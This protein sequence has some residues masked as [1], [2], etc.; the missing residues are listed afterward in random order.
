M[1]STYF[2]ILI[3]ALLAAGT[4]FVILTLSSLLGRKVS[5][6]AKLET[7][8]CG[9]AN[10]DS[11]SK[12]TTVRFYLIAMMFIV[13]DVEAAFLYP[14]TLIMKSLKAEGEWVPGFT[15]FLEILVFLSIL[16]LGYVYVWKKG[17]LEWD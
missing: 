9:V 1:L 6:P 15:G 10:V 3:L 13:F 17:A 8:E 16:M 11:V 2:P 7:Y 14:Y 4:A 5:N 12:P